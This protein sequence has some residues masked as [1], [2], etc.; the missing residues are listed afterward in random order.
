MLLFESLSAKF[1]HFSRVDVV[2]CVIISNSHF[3]PLLGR[4]MFGLR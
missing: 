1:L 3:G 4:S 2:G